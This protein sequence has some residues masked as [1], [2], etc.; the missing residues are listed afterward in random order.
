MKIIETFIKD[1]GFN[2]KVIKDD[3]VMGYF[4]INNDSNTEFILDFT[5]NNFKS[6]D[7]INDNYSKLIDKNLRIVYL[8]E[9]NENIDEIMNFLENDSII[10]ELF[11]IYDKDDE[12]EFFLKDL[13]NVILILKND[14]K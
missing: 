11:L 1:Y 2:T 13:W 3:N 14:S 9:V 6:V 7:K 8:I 5:S 12:L 4:C 10:D